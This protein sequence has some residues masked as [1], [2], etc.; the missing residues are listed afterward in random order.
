M[1]CTF[2]FSLPSRHLL[3][4]QTALGWFVVLLAWFS[5]YSQQCIAVS[6]KTGDIQ[7]ERPK[8]GT[9]ST[10]VLRQTTARAVVQWTIER[11]FNERPKGDISFAVVEDT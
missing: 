10:H 2:V 3:L 8:F 4:Y 9:H 6:C 7:S 5:W 1:S 11:V